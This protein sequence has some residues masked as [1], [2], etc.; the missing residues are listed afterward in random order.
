MKTYFLSVVAA[1]ASTAAMAGS[2]DW[3]VHTPNSG[4]SDANGLFVVLVIVGAILAINGGLGSTR[5]K[6]DATDVQDDDDVIMK[7]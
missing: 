7:F 1:L 6:A 5:G 4:G 2:N 3:E